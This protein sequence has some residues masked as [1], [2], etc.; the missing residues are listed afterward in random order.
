MDAA[1]AAKRRRSNLL[2][3]AALTA[4]LLALPIFTGVALL[5][6]LTSG[7]GISGSRQDNVIFF[8][9]MTSLLCGFAAPLLARKFN[10][11]TIFYEP[12]FYDA[13][14]SLSDKFARWR[15]QPSTSLRLLTMLLMLSVLAVAVLSVE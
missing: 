15:T 7:L 10:L 13:S 2:E 11:S 9:I 14:L 8:V 4:T 5:G 1:I 12:L 3:G 6:R